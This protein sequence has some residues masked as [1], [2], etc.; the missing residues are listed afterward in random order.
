MNGR[1]QGNSIVAQFKGIHDREQARE[2]MDT[3]IFIRREQLESLK[4]D[5]YYWHDL[6]GLKVINLE[7]IVFG[8]ISHFLATG[9]NDVMVVKSDTQERLVPFTLQ[10]AVQKVDIE[11]GIITVDWD[12]DF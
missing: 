7:G 3:P 5:E 8:K 2:M 4:K 6:V 9:S 1:V 10:H 11:Q 12:P